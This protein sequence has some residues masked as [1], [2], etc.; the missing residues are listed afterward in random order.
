[1]QISEL[2]PPCHID[3]CPQADTEHRHVLPQQRELLESTERIVALS[4]GYGSGKTLAMMVMGH[5]LSTHVKGNM[6]IVTRRSLPKLRDSTQRIYLEVLDR[7]KADVE[8]REVRDGWPGRIIYRDTGSEVTFRETKDLGRFLGPEYGWFACDEMQEEPEKVL[9]DLMGRLRLPRAAK[10][11]K[12]MMGTNPPRKGHWF[13][14]MFPKPGAWTREA[15]V[16]GK[17]V[18]ITFRMIQSKTGDNPFLDPEYIAQLKLTHTAEELRGILSGEYRTDYDGKP[19]YKPPFS[20]TWH[21]GQ[22]KTRLMTVARS[23]DFGYHHPV[24]TWSQMF[25]CPKQ[26]V[27]MTVLREYLPEDLDAPELADGVLERSRLWF[28]EHTSNLF[29]DCGDVAGMAVSDKGPGPM[30]TLAA[31]PWNLRFRYQHIGDMDP[32]LALTRRLLRD[33]CACGHFLLEVDRD[34]PEVIEMLNGGYHYGKDKFGAI[35]VD[36]KP[37][38]DGYYDNIADSVRYAVWVLYRVAC[39]DEGFMQELEHWQG[40]P[41]NANLVDPAEHFGWMGDWG[42]VDVDPR[43]LEEAHEVAR[44]TGLRQD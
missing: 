14:K 20:H 21:V 19:V 25:R 30:V 2:F 36:A 17:M 23:W 15:D 1:M 40:P 35:K 9:K 18:K 13:E 43:V 3:T 5:L 37:V 34:C 28:P 7:S 11:L 27:H 39:R 22:F 33:K 44:L 38:K 10:Y 42:Q 26:S 24:V 4:G 6:G 32:G 12:G 29:V 31:P 8:F 41:E 16:A